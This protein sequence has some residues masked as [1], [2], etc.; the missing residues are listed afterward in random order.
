[1][2]GL[3]VYSSTLWKLH[4]KVE[5]TYLSQQV[6]EFDRKCPE[7]WCVVGN[8]F[9]LQKDHEAAIK[10]FQRAFQIDPSF[11]YAYTLIGHEYVSNDQFDK[12]A[13]CFR[14]AIRIDDRHYNAWSGLAYVY[15]R[16]EKF[17]LAEVREK[18]SNHF[19][20]VSHYHVVSF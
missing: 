14:N 11:T 3:E 1:M 13:E 10:F 9:S 18:D 8:C 6:V 12:A 2:E 17:D 15:F 20:T 4:Q 7:T 16:E 5:L 19:T